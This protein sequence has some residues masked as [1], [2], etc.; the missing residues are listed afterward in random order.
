MK[1]IKFFLIIVVGVS[2]MILYSSQEIQED[3]VLSYEEAKE[4]D[5][6]DRS[7][8]NSSGS[9]NFLPTS[10]SGQI[11][12]HNY[13]T[14]SYNEKW[15]QA[16]WVAYELK[17]G[18]IKKNRFKRPFFIEDPKVKTVSAD[19]RNF[20]NSGF[21]K[22]HLCPA[23][24]MQFDSE[25][26][27][28][29]FYTSNIS[30]Q[31]RAFNGG[32]WNRLEEKVRYWAEQYDDVFVVTGGV[33]SPSLKTIGREKV[34]VPE[35]FYKIILDDSKGNFKMIAFLMPNKKSD[36]PLYDF[37]VSMDSIEKMTGIDFFPALDD[38][39]EKELEKSTSYKSWLS[40]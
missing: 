30:P 12:I 14:L 23:A 2:S 8:V 39:I 37:V 28:D 4:L 25:A 1:Y 9:F 32:I 29:T 15:E 22:G 5:T 7:E 40:K 38:K 19:W 6:K 27:N 17:K 34:A 36:K 16:E 24:D 31:D 3:V 33:L 18:Y 11:V 21:D 26:Y 35:F 13:Y 20:K 10:T